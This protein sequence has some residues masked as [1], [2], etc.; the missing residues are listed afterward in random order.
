MLAF[1]TAHGDGTFR[2]SNGFLYGV[3][4]GLIGLVP[5]SAS[6]RDLNT[7]GDTRNNLRSLVKFDEPTC[8]VLKD[9]KM[10]FGN[11]TIDTN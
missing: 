6:D 4:A 8:C 7:E 11:I 10:W 1:G 5:V 9:G 3:D 2:G